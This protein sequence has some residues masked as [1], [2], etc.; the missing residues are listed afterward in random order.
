M[1][2]NHKEKIELTKHELELL[3]MCLRHSIETLRDKHDYG[4]EVLEKA[5]T[6][7]LSD[8]RERFVTAYKEGNRQ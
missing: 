3:E 5:L 1:R 2:A 7:L 8:I 6:T 4:C